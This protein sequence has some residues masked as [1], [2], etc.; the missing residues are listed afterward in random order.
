[1]IQTEISKVTLLLFFLLQANVLSTLGIANNK[2]AY[3]FLLLVVLLWCFVENKRTKMGET[4]V[5]VAFFLLLAMRFVRGI[6]P[7]S[8]LYSTFFVIPSLIT[9]TIPDKVTPKNIDLFRFAFACCLIYIVVEVGL[10]MFEFAT[11]THVLTWIDS[12]Y[13]THLDKVQTRPVGLSGASLT[14][15]YIITAFSY[16]VLQLPLKGK[17]KYSFW[18]FLFIGLVCFQGRMSILFSFLF[19]LFYLASQTVSRKLPVIVL[20]G[21][22]AVIVAGIALF[23]ML[24][25]GDRFKD[26][27]DDSSAL[28]RLQALVFLGNSELDNLFWGMSLA[29][30]KDVQESMGVTILEIS[31]LVHVL[32]FGFFFSTFFYGITMYNA[33][34]NRKESNKFLTWVSVVLFFLLNTTSTGWSSGYYEV[35]MMMLLFKLFSDKTAYYI[36]P[37]QYLDEEYV[38]K[39]KRRK[40]LQLVKASILMEK[41][42]EKKS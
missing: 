35:A 20:I 39:Q 21:V 27:D 14:N 31:Y 40:L 15:S 11:K 30:M 8:I 2:I 16:V 9:L 37:R 18:L 19:L 28:M 34:R 33:Y 26:M 23:F 41:L 5:L 6:L 24:G 3:L 12:V 4:L 7:E 10:G 36:I 42:Q 29:K 25:L 13:E 22:M 38:K 17:Y 1:M 32:I